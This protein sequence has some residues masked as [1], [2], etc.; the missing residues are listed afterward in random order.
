MHVGSQ[1][2]QK[3]AVILTFIFTPLFVHAFLDR[4]W[5]IKTKKLKNFLYFQPSF[6]GFRVFNSENT[7]KSLFQN[8]GTVIKLDPKNRFIGGFFRKKF[9]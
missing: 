3:S 1:G 5:D 6:C 4:E 9:F 7:N 8:K 2:V